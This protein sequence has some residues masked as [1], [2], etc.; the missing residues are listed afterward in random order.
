[1]WRTLK[2]KRMAAMKQ[3]TTYNARFE[4]DP[5][6]NWLAGL[7]EIPQIHTFGKTLGKARENLVDA[8]AQWLGKHVLDVQASIELVPS[9]SL[10]PQI[11]EAIDL[12]KGAKE[13]A[14]AV[15]RELN[16]L[17]AA[18]A[19]ALVDDG[20]LSVRDAA[21]MLGI[22]HQRVH[23]IV[24]SVHSE[25]R[26]DEIRRNL[27]LVQQHVGQQKA[28]PPSVGLS[29]NNALLAIALIVVGGALIAGTASS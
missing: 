18:A 8:L 19:L 5:S 10:P 3:R 24:S 16:D 14:D 4:L 15:V 1:M 22:S 11:Q 20:H 26:A 17:T 13:I 27:A 7:D 28:M 12:V 21:G 25:R 2:E 29:P 9:V 23:Q 6:G